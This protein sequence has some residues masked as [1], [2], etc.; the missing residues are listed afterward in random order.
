MTESQ[1]GEFRF[2]EGQRHWELGARIQ[3]FI[4]ES[5]TKVDM[6][7]VYSDVDNDM[8]RSFSKLLRYTG[9]D[10]LFTLYVTTFILK[11]IIWATDILCETSTVEWRDAMEH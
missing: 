7:N 11:T 8:Q 1:S 5:P 6:M 3:F 4:D 10:V 9:V 2:Y